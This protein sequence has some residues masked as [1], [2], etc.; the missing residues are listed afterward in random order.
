M[1]GGAINE[2]RRKSS[3]SSFSKYGSVLR[4]ATRKAVALSNWF[5]GIDFAPAQMKGSHIKPKRTISGNV[6]GIWLL[7]KQIKGDFYFYVIFAIQLKH[8]I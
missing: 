4:W 3:L 1:E 7:L 2:N 8:A 6:N 5:V